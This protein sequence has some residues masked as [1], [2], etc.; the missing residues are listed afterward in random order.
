MFYIYIIE[1]KIN[2]NIYVGKTKN[3]KNRKW[4]HFNKTVN[5]H[6][7]HAMI[8]YGQNNFEFIPIQAYHTEFE[9]FEAEKFWISELK[10]YDINLYNMTEGGEGVTGLI[11]SE[12]NKKKMSERTKGNNHNLGRKL[13]ED[14]KNKISKA[15]KGKK[16][17][18]EHLANLSIA[19]K[20]RQFTENMRNALRNAVKGKKQTPEHI[21]KCRLTRIGKKRSAE[22]CQKISAGLTG[23]KLSPEHILN[24]SE[25]HKGH[26]HTQEQKDKIGAF[27][28]G[29]TWKIIGGKRVWCDKK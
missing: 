6:L 22:V 23:K 7:K 1:N 25:S 27:T 12:E 21:E 18:P 10:K 8:K 26:V 11:V 5:M 29:R 28:R 24:L 2:G 9:C 17:S 13:P 15:L 19:M 14:Q 4:A 16:K 20:G 3:L